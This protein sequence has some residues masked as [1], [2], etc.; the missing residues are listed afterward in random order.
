M[1]FLFDS[2]FPYD[3][4]CFFDCQVPGV[5]MSKV[6]LGKDS[7]DGCHVDC[8]FVGFEVPSFT[9]TPC[10]GGLFHRFIQ[11]SRDASGKTNWRIG[12]LAAMRL[13]DE[14]NTVRHF[15]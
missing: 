4:Q 10:R 7:S 5:N 12:G 3:N 6:Q 8:G 2:T 13:F 11:Q 9:P 1:V 15:V 14:V